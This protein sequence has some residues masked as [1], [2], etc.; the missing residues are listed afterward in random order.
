MNPVCE[1]WSLGSELMAG[2]NLAQVA[3]IKFLGPSPQGQDI[4]FR[5]MIL[6]DSSHDS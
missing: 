1:N 5:F 3:Q 4:F 2:Y 6:L